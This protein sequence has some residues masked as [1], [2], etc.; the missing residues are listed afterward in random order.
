VTLIRPEASAALWRLREVFA[1]VAL[2]GVGAWLAALGGYVLVPL[3]AAVIVLAAGF[4][5]LAWRRMRF[6]Q[7]GVAPGVVEFDEG[8][9]SYFGPNAGGAVALRELVELRLMTLGGRRVWRLKQQDGQALLI[10]VEA[11]GAERLF[12]AFAALPGMDTAAL[13]AAVGGARSV[14]QGRGLVS[15]SDSRVIWRHPVRPALT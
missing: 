10:P 1:A 8:Q 4:G 13:V 5:V 12:D 3:G 9:V 11:M 14:A 7:V 6:A 15:A 2:G